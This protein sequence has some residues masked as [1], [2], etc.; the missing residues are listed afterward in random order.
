MEEF[1]KFLGWVTVV[2]FGLSV[3]NYVVKKLNFVLR[4]KLDKEAPVLVMYT[5]LMKLI[6]RYHLYF[7]IGAGVF[8]LLHLCLQLSAGRISLTGL[9]AV[10]LMILTVVCGIL[11]KKTGAA[12]RKKVLYVH[13]SLVVMVILVVIVHLIQM[14]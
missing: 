5:K 3:L 13:R 6:I 11:L 2:C 7:G 8:A 1:G 14:G 4:K 9:I 10:T 12:A